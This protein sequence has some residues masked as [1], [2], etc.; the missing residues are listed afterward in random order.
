MTGHNVLYVGPNL[1]FEVEPEGGHEWWAT[2]T[3]LFQVTDVSDEPDFQ[4]RLIFG[5]E[6]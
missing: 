5:F 4:V 6:F 3:P 1:A 2:I